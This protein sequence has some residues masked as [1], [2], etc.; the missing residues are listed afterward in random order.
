VEEIIADITSR[1]E[2]EH[3]WSPAYTK[4]VPKIAAELAD[5]ITDPAF[6]Q[7]VKGIHNLRAAAAIEDNIA[8]AETLAEDLFR[9]LIGGRVAA[10][11]TNIDSVA[12]RNQQVRD[13]FNKFVYASGIF[14][15]Q[16]GQVA[17]SVFQAAAQI[18]MRNGKLK[19]LANEEA[20]S[21]VGS[22]T[23]RDAASRQI[24]A[25]AV[26]SINSFFKTTN[27]DAY[28][29]AGRERL[30]FPTTASIAKAQDKL[31]EA[32]TNYATHINEG[33]TL[34][35]K[36][37]V[38]AWEKKFN[39]LQTKLDAARQ[40]A[41]N[42]N[43]PTRHWSNGDWVSSGQYDYKLAVSTAR[44]NAEDTVMTEQGLMPKSAVDTP[45]KYSS[46]VKL[47][48]AQTKKWLTQWRKDNNVRVTDM[49]AG[50][51]EEETQKIVNN[52]PAYEALPLEDAELA[53]HLVQEQIAKP[54]D[55]ANIEINANVMLDTTNYSVPRN[56]EENQVQRTRTEQM[57][58]RHSATSGRA[59]LQPLLVHGETSLKVNMAKIADV[60]H[61]LRSKYVRALGHLPLTDRADLFSKAFRYAMANMD[62]PATEEKI[63]QQ[64][65][66]DIRAMISTTFG[67]PETTALTIS[68]LDP[69]A[70][71][72]AF[73]K[74]GLSIKN[75]MPSV[76]TMNPK[77]ISNLLQYMPFAEMP[78]A[79]K[80]TVEGELWAKRAADFSQSG[81]DPFLVLTRLMSAVQF[82]KHERAI[83]N[84]FHTRFGWQN[85]F[86]TAEEAT[87]AGWVKPTGITA[88][89]MD[90]TAMLPEVAQGG[91]YDPYIAKEF[92][93]VNREWNAIFH[94]EGMSKAVQFM[95]NWAGFFKETQTILNLRHHI[96]NAFGDT[97]IEVLNGTTNPDHWT[98]AFKM[99]MRYATEDFRSQWG[100]NKFDTK[101]KH[102]F[103]LNKNFNR[104]IG[105]E[106]AT[107]PPVITINK[108][109]KTT[110]QTLNLEDLLAAFEERGI[111]ISNIFS[112]DI[113]GLQES[114]LQNVVRPDAQKT[115]GQQVVAKI[116][117][118]REKITKVPGTAAAWYGNVPRIAGALRII[119]ER[120]WKSLD[121]ALDAATAEVNRLH[122]TIQSL[123]SGE[124]KTTRIAITYYTWLRVAHNV[125]I[126]MAINHTGALMVPSKLQFN[127]AQANGMAP[128]S[129]G[130]PWSQKLTEMLPS[131]LTNSPYGPMWNDAQGK[132][133]LI[134]PSWLPLDVLSTWT[135][136]YDP[137][138]STGDN[139]ARNILEGGKIIGAS[140]NVAVQPLLDVIAGENLQTHQ[141]IPKTAQG[142]IDVGLS[143][144]GQIALAKALTDYTPAGKT[145]TP[146]DRA[147]TLRNQIAGL[148]ETAVINDKNLQNATK[149]KNARLKNIIAELNKGKK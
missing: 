40:E 1:A 22:A 50:L 79:M 90:F 140:S 61:H 100:A 146:E 106:T 11:N 134:K 62:V 132:P 97:S 19:A 45:S 73:G 80:G 70:L 71:A 30:P 85:F 103:N 98:N 133:V 33:K 149:E 36:A 8:S 59:N 91:L 17:Q 131:Y 111:A 118:G 119:E 15:Q 69:E 26:E 89:G 12:T 52:I 10:L 75:G 63:V 117:L 32:E 68:G 128:T 77:E 28:A 126:D 95:M 47:N 76:S 43:I 9:S 14:E 13:W 86:N 104:T 42:N 105:E 123:A 139:A 127:V 87:A 56:L 148:R 108:N 72:K 38:I 116:K 141:A 23:S 144:F 34:T 24:F 5:A 93:S 81:E 145:L 120:S 124:R 130:R 60:A 57:R 51:V 67:N 74:F 99:S 129:I 142:L 39:T 31:T 125:F 94:E 41:W 3:P 27:S 65:S 136:A 64:M 7:A 2:M 138:Y 16:S 83:V 55:D 84:D 20:M 96:T 49:H 112:N 82:A 53:Q 35:S 113:M 58:Q 137:A 29:G 101:I 48:A 21:L 4:Q 92:F 114:V 66:G 25:D 115:L 121:D 147:R 107:K 110:T 54:L 109:G 18:F 122:P 37:Q 78:T 135:F 102:L 6:V 88:N 143:N 46:H 44:K